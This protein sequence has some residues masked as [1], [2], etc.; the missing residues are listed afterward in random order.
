LDKQIEEKSN[1][2]SK[3]KNEDIN[4]ALNMKQYTEQQEAQD[5]QKKAKYKTD[6][7]QYREILKRQIEDNSKRKLFKDVMSDHERRVNSLDLDAYQ[8]MDLHLHSKIVGAKDIEEVNTNVINTRP[9]K[10][11]KHELARKIDMVDNA[12]KR[13]GNNLYSRGTSSRIVKLAL[14]NM[15]DPRV[16]YMRNN[17]QNRIYGCIGDPYLIINKSLVVSPTNLQKEGNKYN[18]LTNAGRAQLSNPIAIN[19]PRRNLP[20][21]KQTPYNIIT[22]TN[23]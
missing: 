8:K 9:I 16:E 10:H 15:K 21:N 5:K 17:T 3:I 20:E 13:Q 22:G 23:Y 12:M 6:I 4:Y 2:A 14:E 1:K 7:Q 18:S 11:E 19:L